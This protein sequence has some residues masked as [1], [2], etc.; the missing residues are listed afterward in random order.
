[1]ND[2][3]HIKSNDTLLDLLN[4]FDV[5]SKLNQYPDL[6]IFI[7]NKKIKGILTLGDL[8]RIRKNKIDFK[9]KAINYLNEN[10]IVLKYGILENNKFNYI[11]NLCKKKKLNTDRL[12]YIF[13]V[14]K[15]SNFLGVIDGQNFL[16]DYKHK[17]I[18]LIGMGFVGLCLSVHMSKF[19]N[20]IIGVDKD[21]K[22]I[23]Q[24]NKGASHFLEPGLNS[25]LNSSLV[26]KRIL[27]K[28]KIIE[29]EVYI[30]CF[31][32]ED[33]KKTSNTNLLNFIKSL[34]KILKKKDLIILRGTVGIG[35]TN[36]V[37]QLIKKSIGFQSGEDY[38][39]SYSPERIVE[40]NAMQE[41]E[42]IPQII[43]GF[44]ER[45]LKQASLF[46]KISINEIVE[47]S[48]SYEAEIIKLIN[49][50]YRLY[51]FSFSNLISLLSEKYN[52]NVKQ[53][54]EKANYGYPRNKLHMPSVGVGGFCLL[55]DF[56]ILG[57]SS[58]NKLIINNLKIINKVNDE[59]IESPIR[60]IKRFEKETKKKLKT[61]LI[62]GVAF[63]GEPQT[64]DCRN[65][66]GI[67]LAN[68]LIKKKYKVYLY[69][70]VAKESDVGFQ[71]MKKLIFLKQIN[72]KILKKIDGIIIMNN[73]LINK[74]LLPKNLS[75]NTSPK[76][77]FDGY[78]QFDP[79]VLSGLNYQYFTLGYTYIES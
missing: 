37:E 14:D 11:N 75:K 38:F 12:K 19:H 40:G 22:I 52:I 20:Q 30:L 79:K 43:S 44:S 18:C 45:C 53:L 31:G 16:T 71:N 50:S 25:I 64:N 68:K 24:L 46:W 36:K 13:E 73:N 67:I 33:G 58:S 61:I 35:T 5:Q 23:K 26:N 2:F 65:S 49:N 55:K 74:T 4:Y 15:N 60:A 59:I 1:M 34:C 29:S 69:D 72:M 48:N 27:F 32:T 51:S 8:R 77:F 63:K 9:K 7:K 54:L 42:S 41:L 28:E 3:L 66:P 62:T 76:F 17:R 10:P 21:K 57:Q 39:L 70:N 78:K 6:A 47:T 56:N